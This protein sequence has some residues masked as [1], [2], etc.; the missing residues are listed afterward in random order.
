MESAWGMTAGGGLDIK[1]TKHVSF[2]PF[3][4]EYFLTR[5]RNL[6]TFDDDNQNNLRY[7]AGVKSAGADSLP[8][9][10]NTRSSC[11]ICGAIGFRSGAGPAIGH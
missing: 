10:S 5:L 7:S 3:Q 9:S 1:I 8:P 6:R 11:F 2:R 4:I